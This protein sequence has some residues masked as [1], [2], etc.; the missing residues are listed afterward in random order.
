M[1]GNNL[2]AQSSSLKRSAVAANAKRAALRAWTKGSRSERENAAASTLAR[3]YHIVS[4]RYL[5]KGSCNTYI[6][7]QVARNFPQADG[8][9]RSDARLL[10]I[11]SLCQMS[12]KFAVYGSV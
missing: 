6:Y 12:Q 4:L 1:M 11:C 2:V 7:P 8:R 10:I 3:L 5:L 9:I